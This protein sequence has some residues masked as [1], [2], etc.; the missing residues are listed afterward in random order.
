MS[1]ED[2]PLGS[3]MALCICSSTPRK[4]SSFGSHYKNQCHGLNPVYANNV[5]SSPSYQ[6]YS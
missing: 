3:G 2:I 4:C 6:L 5:D 1:R